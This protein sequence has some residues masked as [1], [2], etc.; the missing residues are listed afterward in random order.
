MAFFPIAILIVF[1]LMYLLRTRRTRMCRW[2][3]RGK[4][5]WRCAACGAV[6]ITGD[7][8]QPRVCLRKD[9]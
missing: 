5:D 6:A 4:T 8:K 9:I 1:L 3:R 2:R 7:D